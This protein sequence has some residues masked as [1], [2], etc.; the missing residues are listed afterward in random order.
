MTTFKEPTTR[1]TRTHRLTI[2][3][4]LELLSDGNIPLRFTAFELSLIHI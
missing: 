4:I 3:E 1:E 2:S